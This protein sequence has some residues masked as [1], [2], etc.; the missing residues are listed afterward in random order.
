MQ[1]NLLWIFVVL[2]LFLANLVVWLYTRLRK[3]SRQNKAFVTDEG[4]YKTHA[5]ND[6]V[7]RPKEQRKTGIGEFPY[8]TVQ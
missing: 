6:E 5:I 8:K 1:D 2:I 7:E 3:I 4:D